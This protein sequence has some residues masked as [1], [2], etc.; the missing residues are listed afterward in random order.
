MLFIFKDKGSFYFSAI[1][2]L[3]IIQEKKRKYIRN[4]KQKKNEIFLAK[5][6]PT[7]HNFS[8]EWSLYWV[9]FVKDLHADEIVDAKIDIKKRL[10]LPLDFDDVPKKDLTKSPTDKKVEKKF[11]CEPKPAPE[12]MPELVSE[13]ELNEAIEDIDNIS[14]D[15]ESIIAGLQM[16]GSL[17]KFLEKEEREDITPDKDEI[18]MDRISEE[19]FHLHDRIENPSA[20]VIDSDDDFDSYDQR[21]SNLHNKTKPPSLIQISE[22]E[23]DGSELNEESLTLIAV[24]RILT[25]FE[26]YLGSLGPKILDLLS[27]AIALEKVKPNLADEMLMTEANSVLL[28]LCKEK[29]T[30]LLLAEII[31]KHKIKGVKKSIKNIKAIVK[32]IDRKVEEK[33]ESEKLQAAVSSLSTMPAI[34]DQHFENLRKLLPSIISSKSNSN[35]QQ[36]SPSERIRPETGQFSNFGEK[37]LFSRNNQSIYNEQ[38]DRQNQSNVDLK[39][40]QQKLNLEFSFLNPQNS[41]RN[42]ASNPGGNNFAINRSQNN[43]SMNNVYQSQ[44][45]S[46]HNFMDQQNNQQQNQ[47][48]HHQMS[49]DLRQQQ[50]KDIQ[51]NSETSFNQRQSFQQQT[52]RMSS[53]EQNQTPF[54]Q[55]SGNLMPQ[56]LKNWNQ[57]QQ[58]QSRNIQQNNPKKRPSQTNVN[59]CQ[60]NYKTLKMTSSAADNNF[61]KTQ[62]P[63]EKTLEN[64]SMQQVQRSQQQQSNRQSQRNP[65]NNQQHNQQNPRNQM[66]LQQRGRPQQQRNQPQQKNQQQQRNLS[67]QQQQRNQSY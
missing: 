53:C 50:Q 42:L 57:S 35:V 37:S 40:A 9:D 2:T 5:K 20:K 26:D 54:Q 46:Q 4:T 21:H 39:M 14:S 33:Q 65:Q 23:S 24:L 25:A 41:S 22:D 64:S 32:T 55:M 36:I 48:S 16:E 12:I 60:D 15:A 18:L 11:E 29:L 49:S 58:N 43:S 62:S 17:D 27:K 51:Q 6:D 10:N 67:Q 52:Q 31:E 47:F 66:N 30:G 7:N 63:Q 56:N 1:Y 3:Y 13:S 44:L 19:S 8:T 38:T 34:T 28:E 59:Q 61:Y 45:N